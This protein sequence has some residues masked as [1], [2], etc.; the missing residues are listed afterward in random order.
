[1]FCRL[2][3]PISIIFAASF[4]AG[5]S[6]FTAKTEDSLEYRKQ[7]SLKLLEESRTVK[8][9]SL[10]NEVDRVY[11]GKLNYGVNAEPKP[12]ELRSVLY[13]NEITPMSLELAINRISYDTGINIYFTDSA[14]VFLGLEEAS[15]DSD[16][17]SEENTDTTN[18]SEGASAEEQLSMALESFRQT[19]ETLNELKESQ[20]GINPR[21]DILG[22]ETLNN[23]VTLNVQDMTL[24]E[25]INDF[26]LER[27]LFW[28]YGK[29]GGKPYVEISATVSASIQFEGML[30]TTTSSGGVD[31]ASA[32]AW[33][34]IKAYAEE[35]KSEIGYVSTS[36]AS[37]R[38]YVKDRP[39]IVNDLQ[40]RVSTENEVFGQNIYYSLR[41]LTFRQSE[42]ENIQLNWTSIYD[43]LASTLTLSTPGSVGSGFSANY[44]FSDPTSTFAGSSATATALKSVLKGARE[45][46]ANGKTRNRTSFISAPNQNSTIV[47]GTEVTAT[48]VGSVVSDITGVVRS[49]ITFDIFGSILSGGRVAID[50]SLVY[51]DEISRET[52]TSEN[53]DI[54]LPTTYNVPLAPRFILRPGET[55]IFATSTSNISSNKSG[56]HDDL[57]WVNMLFGG[58]R[59]SS[60]EDTL[61]LV[62]L[63]AKIVGQ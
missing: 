12:D 59:V 56:I 8:E 28:S 54:T 53:G 35:I 62:L 45:A 55:A 16:E 1:M 10:F 4:L 5:C 25:W 61:T 47:T 38:L 9:R 27:G 19:R 41:V 42:N 49:G 17:N 11:L 23:S 18:N 14:K 21:S 39:S 31:E 37:G 46:S 43:D 20:E 22:V 50:M 36:D 13:Y 24:E 57:G 58:S 33:T 15:N 34:E 30:N 6:S 40:R 32:S 51:D 48:E 63:E 29:V 52:R 3:T 44:V 60:T 26:T 7:S 2:K